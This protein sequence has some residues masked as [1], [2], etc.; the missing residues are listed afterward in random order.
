[1]QGLYNATGLTVPSGTRPGWTWTGGQ[2]VQ[3][4]NLTY[5]AFTIYAVFTCSTAGLL[6]GRGN[7]GSYTLAFAD[8]VHLDNFAHSSQARTIT[9]ERGVTN[10][11]Y[12]DAP[13]S[14]GVF[15]TAKLVVIQ[16]NGT[17]AS[18][19]I[20]LNNAAQTMS[21]VTF[22]GAEPGTGTVTQALQLGAVPA[23][24]GTQNPTAT[25]GR[26]WV[27]GAAH[28]AAQQNAFY[29]DCQNGGWCA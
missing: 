25:V 8:R 20:W 23:I 1:M 6:F 17:K 22:S 2:Y 15:S 26:F 5:G 13:A 4:P 29:Y 12:A 3:T 27:Y 24:S 14:W 19:A 11:C 28:T 16:Y 9:I 10:Y 18:L 21:N 7:P